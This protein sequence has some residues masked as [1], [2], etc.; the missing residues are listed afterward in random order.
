MAL[1]SKQA[2]LLVVALATAVGAG[3]AAVGSTGGDV[4]ADIGDAVGTEDGAEVP[5]SVGATAETVR[6][7]GTASVVIEA[8]VG[9]EG[10]DSRR[11]DT[12]TLSLRAEEGGEPAV[13][14]D[15]RVTLRPG[16]ET[17]VS[18]AV[19]A[20]E[21]GPGTWR[22]VVAVGDDGTAASTD[23]T[24]SVSAGTYAVDGRAVMESPR[25]DGSAVDDGAADAGP[26][27]RR[28]SAPDPDVPPGVLP[29]GGVVVVAS[30][31]NDGDLPGEPQVRLF[32]DRD[33][34]GSFDESEAVT[35]RYPTVPAGGEARVRIP[36][37]TAG[38]EP[39]TYAYRLDV[40][41]RSLE[42]TF[43]V[44]EPAS[45][46]VEPAG[47][48]ADV[49][50]GENATLSVRVSN[51]GQVPGERTLTLAGHNDTLARNV[52]LRGNESATLSFAVDTA[53]HARGNYTYEAAVG[54]DT[55][56]LDLRVRDARFEMLGYSLRGP[57][58]LTLGEELTV[59]A[60]VKNTGDAN[61]TQTIRLVIDLDDDDEPEGY[62]VTRE[63]TLAPGEET[64]VTFEGITRETLSAGSDR[65]LSANDMLGTHIYGL[66][67]DDTAA[68]GVLVI[69][70]RPTY[71]ASSGGSGGSDGGDGDEV[72]R[73]SRDEIAQE[74]YGLDYDE[75][76]AET[77]GQIDEIYERQ[78][79]AEGLA[80][81]DVLTREEIARERYG[82]DVDP[83]ED[84][85]FTALDVELQQEIEADFDA[86]FRSDAGD[87]VESWDEIARAEYGA[88]YEELSS[89]NQSDVRQRYRDQFDEWHGD[90]GSEDGSDD[91]DT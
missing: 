40:G 68:T 64:R 26:A 71:G 50:R 73:V 79:F 37:S 4:G 3:V 80:V 86:Q 61:G 75:V 12:V 66:A 32:V 35:T 63:V 89:E 34:D 5:L 22:Y 23:G 58:V 54:N 87:R 55:A 57:E 27:R 30:V 85:E 25:A 19:P 83:W 38:L 24:V 20:D 17:V 52:S 21:L 43:T 53:D 13:T 76:S 70:N 78:P 81:T 45:F 90:S 42:G 48:T 39:G 74:K 9:G 2:V 10:I 11:T 6:E 51:V 41:D 62:N 91:S 31:A 72:E 84:F 18:F 1:A 46:R 56:S 47:G 65:A 82:V 60:R 44:L 28:L 49:V 29:G 8:T 15:R 36:V 33:R 16:A 59:S 69:E 7:D 14:R 67:S 77:Q 88:P